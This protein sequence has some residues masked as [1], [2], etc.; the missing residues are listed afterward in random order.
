MSNTID[1]DS[2]TAI[3]DS[4]IVGNTVSALPHF[5]ARH[6]PTTAYSEIR[7]AASE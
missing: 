6:T 1:S 7:Q 3:Y 5:R 4:S 2:Y